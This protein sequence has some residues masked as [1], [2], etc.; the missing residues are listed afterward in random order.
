MESNVTRTYIFQFYVINAFTLIESF[1]VK[2]K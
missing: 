2:F 1:C